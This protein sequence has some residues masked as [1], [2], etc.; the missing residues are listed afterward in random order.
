MAW[1][2]IRE[3]LKGHRALIIPAGTCEQHGRHLPLNTDTIIAERMASYLSQKTGIAIGPTIEYGVN[4]PCDRF[5][6]GTCSLRPATLRGLL[7]D[8]LACWRLQGFR[9][10]YIITAH[11]DP[12]HFRALKTACPAHARVLDLWDIK[13]NGI[14]EKQQS[15]RH[16]CEAETSLMLHLFPRLIR[17]GDA[18]DFDIPFDTFKQRLF[19]K[20]PS[21]IKGS[22]GSLG[23][24][25]FATERKGRL[26][27]QRMRRIALEWIRSIEAR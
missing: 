17:K 5:F 13:L 21:P 18:S 22:P 27:A 3:Y 7:R 10:F 24:P 25:S 11:G 6:S 1:P 8:I 9:E 23:Y 20:D 26:I 12:L 4:L 16:A 14:L 19:H 15:A 2:Q